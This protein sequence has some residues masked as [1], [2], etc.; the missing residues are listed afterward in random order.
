MF[1][2]IYFLSKIFPVQSPISLFVRTSLSI[3]A[4]IKRHLTAPSLIASDQAVWGEEIKLLAKFESYF[5]VLKLISSIHQFPPCPFPPPSV[6]CFHI[7]EI[8]KHTTS[9]SYQPFLLIDK[10]K[11]L[12]MYSTERRSK[13]LYLRLS[14]CATH[15]SVTE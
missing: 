2:S 12:D 11:S 3:F 1:L 7:G 8:F 14:Y 15:Q 4:L 9:K 13:L 5:Q 6:F 10:K